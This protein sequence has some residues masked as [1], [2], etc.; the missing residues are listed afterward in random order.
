MG[1]DSSF[2]MGRVLQ[3]GPNTSL[4]PGTAELR[5][6]RLHTGDMGGPGLAMQWSLWLCHLSEGDISTSMPQ[7]IPL[8]F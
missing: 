2:W 5:A 4:P 7:L 1:S 8:H 3:R 6:P